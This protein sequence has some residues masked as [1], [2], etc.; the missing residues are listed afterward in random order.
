[1]KEPRGVYAAL[2]LSATTGV[3]GNWAREQSHSLKRQHLAVVPRGCFWPGF[4]IAWPFRYRIRFKKESHRSAKRQPQISAASFKGGRG[5]GADG[6][7][8]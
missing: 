8:G 6:S 5:T 2:S 7:T 3:Q 4:T 1:M